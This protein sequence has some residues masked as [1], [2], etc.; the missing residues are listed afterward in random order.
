MMRRIVPSI[1]A[2][3]LIAISALAGDLPP[4]PQP[5]DGIKVLALDVLKNLVETNT[6]HAHGSTGAAEQIAT[7]LRAAS[8]AP[9]LIDLVL[10]LF[11]SRINC[12]LQ[13]RIELLQLAVQVVQHF[14]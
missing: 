12:S 5:P 11:A 1:A 13:R 4:A 9:Q 3:L 8:F 14:H 7:R 10:D 2:T 6:T